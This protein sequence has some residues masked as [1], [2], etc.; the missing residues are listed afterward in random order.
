[1][2]ERPGLQRFQARTFETFGFD[3]L[4]HAAV[5]DGRGYRWQQRGYGEEQHRA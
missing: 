5:H 3:A 1:L 4:C 2:T